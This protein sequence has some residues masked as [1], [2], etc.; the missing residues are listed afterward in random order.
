[1][2]VHI[3]QHDSHQR[4]KE[5][6]TNHNAHAA[7]IAAVE[8]CGMQRGDSAAVCITSYNRATAEFENTVWN[9]EFDGESVYLVVDGERRFVGTIRK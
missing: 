6:P 1:M 7:A 5:I 9:V 4:T 3:F 8:K 2:L